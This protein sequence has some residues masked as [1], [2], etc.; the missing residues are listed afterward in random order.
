[1]VALVDVIRLGYMLLP[2][3]VH[4]QCGTLF[5]PRPLYP[6]EKTANHRS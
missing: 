6:H 3:P 1:M 2:V 4:L 5:L